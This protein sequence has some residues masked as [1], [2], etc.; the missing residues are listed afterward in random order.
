MARKDESWWG[1]TS[2]PTKGCLKM[3]MDCEGLAQQEA[4]GEVCSTAGAVL[5]GCLRWLCCDPVAGAPCRSERGNYRSRRHIQLRFAYHLL[6]LPY[7]LCTFD[8]RLVPA[9]PL[10]A[11]RLTLFPNLAHPL[12]A[13]CLLTCTGSGRTK[14]SDCRSAASFDE[15]LHRRNVGS[16]SCMA[17]WAWS[18][19]SWGLKV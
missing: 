4:A 19:Q 15:R 1:T 2:P 5:L 12:P 6:L 8:S 10:T 13:P 18:L 11:S 9:W 14:P 7:Y 17:A 16:R 3:S